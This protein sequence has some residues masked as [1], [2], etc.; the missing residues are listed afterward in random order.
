MRHYPISYGK[1]R[2]HCK[3]SVAVT[4]EKIVGKSLEYENYNELFEQ[5]TL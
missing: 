1:W 3:R 2:L 4:L 5:E